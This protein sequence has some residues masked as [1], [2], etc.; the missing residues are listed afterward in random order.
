MI[1]IQVILLGPGSGFRSRP[2]YMDQDS[3]PD[4]SFHYNGSGAQAL[5]PTVFQNNESYLENLFFSIL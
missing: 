3:D 2:F 1:R 4:L 5:P